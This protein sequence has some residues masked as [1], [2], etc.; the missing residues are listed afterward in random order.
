MERILVMPSNFNC[1]RCGKPIDSGVPVCP[2]CGLSLSPPSNSEDKA[3]SM[4]SYPQPTA[5]SALKILLN[6]VNVRLV[7]FCLLAAAVLVLC[8]WS[9]NSIASAARQMQQ[10]RTSDGHT[11]SE[12]FDRDLGQVYGGLAMFVRAC[13][14]FFTGALVWFGL[15]DRM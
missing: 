15:K 2:N 10:I 1:P 9:A 5:G 6:K 3:Y 11:V 7:C 4:I 13:G 8:F 14:V 12:V